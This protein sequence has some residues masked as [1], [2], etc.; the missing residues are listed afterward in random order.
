M[1]SLAI[2]LTSTQAARFP[3]ITLQRTI[4]LDTV[5]IVRQRLA[6]YGA[7]P[8]ADVERA[9][10]VIG[11]QVLDAGQANRISDRDWRLDG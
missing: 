5:T 11:K 10:I 4:D 3:R 2:L 8:D 7:A 6:R 1:R 9:Q